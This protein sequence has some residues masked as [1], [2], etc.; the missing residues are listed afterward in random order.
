MLSPDVEQ[1][2]LRAGRRVPV[3]DRILIVDDEEENLDVLSALLEDRWTVYTARDGLEA[4]ELLSAKGPF[5]VVI[6]DQRMPRMTGVELLTEIAAHAPNTVRIVLTAYS[7]VEPMMQALNRGSV[8]RFILKPY[9][10]DEM[11]SVVADAMRLK[12][13]SAAAVELYDVLTERRNKLADTLGS[14]ERAEGHLVTTERVATLGKLVAGILHDLNNH[15]FS[16]SLLLGD[17]RESG[18]ASLEGVAERAW[19]AFSDHLELLRLIHSYARACPLEV[20]RTVIST[21]TFVAKTL[22]VFSLQSDRRGHQIIPRIHPDAAVISVDET[23]LRQALVVLLEGLTEIEPR[24]SLVRLDFMPAEGDDLCIQITVEGRDHEAPPGA[25]DGESTG[26]D[27]GP[28]GL[29]LGIEIAHLVAASHGGQVEFHSVPGRGTR[30]MLW[31]PSALARR[32][33]DE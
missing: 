32:G 15:A 21:E 16:F 20:Q 33:R 8:Y 25:E 28:P 6:A 7:D 9:D 4:F 1:A 31:L 17:I 29:A 30:A 10:A 14:L 22:Q 2:L 24:A 3:C 12:A 5:D 26:S 13:T 23:Q 27:S 11:R 18:R 19:S